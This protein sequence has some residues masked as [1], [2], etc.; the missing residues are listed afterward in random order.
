MFTCFIFSDCI[1]L[2]CKIVSYL[3]KRDAEVL[4]SVFSISKTLMV[5]VL[6]I[7]CNIYFTKDTKFYVL[8]PID[9]MIE[10]VKRIV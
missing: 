1:P 4:S 3:Y 7:I 10:N 8:E 9:L 5:C 6:L 2:K